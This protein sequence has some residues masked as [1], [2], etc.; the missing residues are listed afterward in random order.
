MVPFWGLSVGLCYHKF[1]HSSMKEGS[2]KSHQPLVGDIHT[3]EPMLNLHAYTM[4][5][6]IQQFLGRLEGGWLTSM[7]Q[8]ILFSGGHAVKH[9]YLHTIPTSK[10]SF[11]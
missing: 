3:P 4:A 8:I 2:Y 6:S 11:T 1:V 9:K 7:G 10:D 5:L